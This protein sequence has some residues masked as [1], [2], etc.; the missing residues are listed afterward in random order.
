[1]NSFKKKQIEEKLRNMFERSK[2]VPVKQEMEAAVTYI[3]NGNI[4]RRR[5]G[6]PD[7]RIM[8]AT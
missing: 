5:K 4:I 2:Q 6:L 1:M 3:G 7:K 8:S